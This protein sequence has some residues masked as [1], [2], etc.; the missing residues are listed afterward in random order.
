VAAPAQSTILGQSQDAF[1]QEIALYRRERILERFLAKDRSLWP[2]D[3]VAEDRALGELAWLRLPEL[4]GPF[5]E[6]LQEC[7]AAADADGLEDRA[8]LALESSNLCA[9]ALLGFSGLVPGRKFVVLDSICP[10][11]IRQMEQRLDLRS[12]LFFLVNKL[13]YHLEDHCLF[14]YFQDQLQL[15]EQGCASRHFVSETEP[16]TYLA[17]LSRQN[18]FR[19][20][21]PD[22]CDIPPHYCSLLHFSGLFNSLRVAEP[23]QILAVVEQ[24]RQSCVQ[25]DPGAA[26]PA[27]QLAAFLTSVVESH[28][29]YLAFLASPSLIEFTRRLGQLVGGSL[30]RDG[31]GLIPL[32]GAVPRDTREFERDTAFVA[33]THPGDQ[34][35]EIADAISR[36]R[37]SATPFLHIEIARPLDLLP[38]SYKWEFATILASARL[39]LNPFDAPYNRLPR[40]FA[41]EMLE[42]LFRGGTPF[43]RLPRLGEQLI[44]LYADGRTRHEISALNMAEALRSFL[45]ISTPGRHVTLL[46]YLPPSPQVDAAFTKIRAKMTEVLKRPVLL[47]YGPLAGRHHGHVFREE[48]SYGPCVIF[49]SDQ[50]LDRNIPGATYTFAQLHEAL[51]LGEYDALVHWERPVIRLHLTAQS[52]LVF[53]QLQHLFDQA[54]RRF[55]A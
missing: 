31:A 30:T 27:L 21:L 33:L 8:L 53:Q 1:Q 35:G 18:A 34:D 3:L 26:N 13:N 12:T 43:Q 24:M 46:V 11:A 48:L 49:T 38:E 42:E 51:S 55:P 19:D 54:L 39:G 45:R 9:R 32:V 23:A 6:A 52:P 41:T 16:N 20:V 15:L 4:L 40:V 17:S 47:V 37:S 44:Q 36:F 22:P 2:E 29:S 28:R 25:L 10:H 50:H 5:L 14:L 7:E